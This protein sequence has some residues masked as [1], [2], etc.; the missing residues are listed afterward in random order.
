MIFDPSFS[1]YS[2][3]ASGKLLASLE[4]YRN[5]RQQL[6]SLAKDLDRGALRSFLFKV[7]NFTWLVDLGVLAGNTIAGVFY[8]YFPFFVF[9][10]FGLLTRLKK[11]PRV[12][13]LF[14]LVILGYGLLFVHVLQYWYFEDRFLYI[15]ILPGSILVAFGIEKTIRFSQARMRWKASVAVIVIS[16]YII[17][18]GL[19][20]NIKQR[21]EDKAVFR[22]IAEYISGLE[23]PGHAF[24]PVLTA[25][26]SS[27]KLVP[28]YVN[29]HLPVGFC[30]FSV[31]P[32]IKNNE[33]LFQYAEEKD[34]KY[35][36][37]DEKN[38]SKTQLNIHS[39]DFRQIFKE[40]KRW[41]AREVGD[42]IL[43]YR[44]Q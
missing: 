10:F 6:S 43:F 39:D 19:G 20:K 1:A 37:W 27:L 12:V 7:R 24:V 4:E 33:E 23:K 9:G 31:A 16:L 42:L 41:N 5:L 11:D 28:F 8:A 35:F 21:E 22:Q 26:S 29:L 13:Y 44:N 32:S 18:F 40:L 17:G 3:K 38:W 15:I 36:L 34:V 25:D 30:P 14:I 2:E